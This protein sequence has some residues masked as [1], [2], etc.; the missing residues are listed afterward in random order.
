MKITIDLDE[1]QQS[2]LLTILSQTDKTSIAIRK[3]ITRRSRVNQSKL[4]STKISRDTRIFLQE[5]GGLVT[6]LASSDSLYK[7]GPHAKEQA[8]NIISSLSSEQRTR[9]LEELAS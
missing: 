8:K 9:L 3:E 4:N 7:L 5:N 1:S 2:H 6:V